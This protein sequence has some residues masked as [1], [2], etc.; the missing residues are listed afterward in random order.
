MTSIITVREAR[1]G[2]LDAVARLEQAVWSPLGTPV[3]ERAQIEAWYRMHS[4]FFLIAEQDGIPCGYYFGQ[5]VRFAMHDCVV[6]FRPGQGTLWEPRPH[7]PNSTSLFGI[8]IV[9]RARGAGS[10][11]YARVRDLSESLGLNY[12]VGISRMS[13]LNAY[14][15]ENPATE[16]YD[17][18][19]VALWYALESA[20]LLGMRSWEACP[21]RPR[22]PLP[23]VPAADPVLRCHAKGGH[24]GIVGLYPKYIEPDRESRDYGVCIVSAYPHRLP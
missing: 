24:F 7:D 15:E 9:S 18:D 21:S 3:L 19:E 4:P 17:P 23:R 12:S 22:L 16:L 1:E 10:A 6:F 8:N 2:D 20:R 13:G 5:L 11:L 14:M